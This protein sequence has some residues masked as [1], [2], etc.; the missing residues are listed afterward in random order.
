MSLQDW[1]TNSWLVEHRTSRDEIRSLLNLAERD[2]RDARTVGL[3]VDWHH[4]IAYN[5][6]LQLAQAALA[7]CGYRAARDQQHLR[8]IRS[9]ELTVGVDPKT[10]RRLDAARKRRNRAA[11]DLAGIIS[12]GEADE[13][14]RCA[15]ELRENIEQWLRAE[16]P[17]L[18]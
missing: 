14:E 1:L 12:E 9:L 6:A 10:V 18:L 7:A 8:T 16:H 15:I 17:E 5:A 2:L 3:S 11:Y 4:N 13:V